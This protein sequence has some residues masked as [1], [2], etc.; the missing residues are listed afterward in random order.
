MRHC[1]LRV[2]DSEQGGCR[3][4]VWAGSDG[5]YD[6]GHEYALEIGQDCNADLPMLALCSHVDE[7]MEFMSKS[8]SPLAN[9]ILKS[10]RNTEKQLEEQLEK[11]RS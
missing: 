7:I 8:E 11:S 9:L 2:R 6:L 3:G 1:Y 4:G 10:M 5:D